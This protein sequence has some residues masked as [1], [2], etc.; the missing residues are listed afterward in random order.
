MP[1]DVSCMPV[2]IRRGDQSVLNDRSLIV[3]RKLTWIDGGSHWPPQGIPCS[4][5]K[6]GEEFL[7]P[8][9]KEIASCMEIEPGIKLVDQAAVFPDRVEANVVGQICRDGEDDQSSEERK[10]RCR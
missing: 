8:M 4:V 2:T 3:S 7:Q 5:I 6:P 10:D 9:L 1:T